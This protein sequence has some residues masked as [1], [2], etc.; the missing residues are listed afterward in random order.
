MLNPGHE[1]V[2]VLNPLSCPTRA[3]PTVDPRIRSPSNNVGGETRGVRRLPD[4][5]AREVQPVFEPSTSDRQGTSL[6]GFDWIPRAGLGVQTV[7]VTWKLL[8][9][10]NVLPRSP[11]EIREPRLEMLDA[12]QCLS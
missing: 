5:T 8:N 1:P 10:S 6:L 11:R 4:H 12:N 7:C 9:P 2:I 3:L